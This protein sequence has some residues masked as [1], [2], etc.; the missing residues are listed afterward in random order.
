MYIGNV[1]LLVLNLPLVGVW[2]QMLKV[3]YS[4]LARL[5]W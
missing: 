4:I 2:V 5:S 3:P 1:L